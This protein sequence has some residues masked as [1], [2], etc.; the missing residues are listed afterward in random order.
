M[1]NKKENFLQNQ[2]E[3]LILNQCQIRTFFLTLTKS[4][5]DALTA[6]PDRPVSELSWAL[7]PF[8]WDLYT[9][10]M[11][12]KP[13]VCARA[14]WVVLACTSVSATSSRNAQSRQ[15]AS[16]GTLLLSVRN[17]FLVNSW[18]TWT[19]G[20]NF[21]W[22]SVFSLG[23]GSNHTRRKLYF[24]PGS[25]LSVVQITISIYIL[26]FPPYLRLICCNLN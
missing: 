22:S 19:R 7:L 8:L 12:E 18:P 5:I 16:L 21:V 17:H 15:N 3:N 13:H 9:L 26:H 2:I 4:T 25:P 11:A 23:R 10:H 24:S 6:G 20:N 14:K 1:S